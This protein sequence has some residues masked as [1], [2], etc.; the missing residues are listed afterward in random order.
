MV[1]QSPGI[2][3]VSRLIGI[4]ASNEASALITG[5][6]GTGK[7]VVARAI[8]ELSRRRGKPFVALNMAAIPETLIESELFGHERGAFTGAI[9]SHPGAFEQAD[10]GTLFLDEIAEMP[11]A[12]QPRLLRILEENRV[13]RLGSTLLP[14]T[15]SVPLRKLRRGFGITELR[16]GLQHVALVRALFDLA[17]DANPVRLIRVV[18]LQDHVE[19]EPQRRVA[20]LLATNLLDAPVDVLARDVRLHLLDAHEVLLVERPQAIHARLELVDLFFDLGRRLHWRAPSR[21]GL[22]T[23]RTRKTSGRG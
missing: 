8:H 19:A 16:F 1:G 2:R 6:S 17:A 5:E 12:L 13:R 23:H 3:E 9:R 22:G 4:L 15:L 10:G 21:F 20:N 18:P 7:E 14:E 11:M